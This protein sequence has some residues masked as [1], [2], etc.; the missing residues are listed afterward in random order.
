MDESNNAIWLTFTIVIIS[1]FELVSAFERNKLKRNQSKYNWNVICSR[2]HGKFATFYIIF[3]ASINQSSY[4]QCTDPLIHCKN[5][6]TCHICATDMEDAII[7]NECRNDVDF[8]LCF[9]IFMRAWHNLLAT[10]ST[11][12]TTLLSYSATL[13]V[14]LEW[15][16]GARRKLRIRE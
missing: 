11:W 3:H 4:M 12:T 9:N 5:T 6:P 1:P 16:A 13:Y 10:K 14:S 15:Y 8:T 7:T 2:L